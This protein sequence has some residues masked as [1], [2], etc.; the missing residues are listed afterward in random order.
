MPTQFSRRLQGRLPQD[1]PAIKPAAV[2]PVRVPL[3]EQHARPLVDRVEVVDGPRV[4]G[5]LVEPVRIER[6]LLQLPAVGLL[7]QLQRGP[8]QVGVPTRGDPDAA[9]EQRHRTDLLVRVEVR[10][11]AGL[12]HGDRPVADEV[13]EHPDRR[14]GTAAGRPRGQHRLTAAGEEE[15]VEQEAVRLMGQ[16]VGVVAA[17]R[18]R[19]VPERGRD[20]FLGLDEIAEGRRTGA[21]QV[22]DPRGQPTGRGEPRGRVAGRKQEPEHLRQRFPEPGV[23][24]AVGEVQISK[25]RGTFK[26]PRQLGEQGFGARRRHVIWPFS[27]GWAG[28]RIVRGNAARPLQHKT[29][30]RREPEKDTRPMP[31][32]RRYD[33]TRP[34]RL[35]ALVSAGGTTLQNLIDRIADGRLNSEIVSVV[36]SNPDAYGNER[37]RRA[38]IPVAIVPRRTPDFAAAV[39][40]AVRAAKP[41]LVVLAG[42]LHLLTIPPDFRF[43]VLNIHPSLLPAFGGKGM[44]GHHVH[45]AVLAYGAKVS[46]CTVH[47]A[48]D[49]YDTGPV[50]MQRAVPVLDDDTPDALTARVFAAECE[51]YPEAIR[52]IAA[53]NWRIDGRRVVATGK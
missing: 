14:L 3:A 44:Y 22:A 53:G 51:A 41:D 6:R 26:P 12:Q 35:V 29:S 11:R 18:G 47:F 24:A 21:F 27:V 49:S 8:H 25:R 46:G 45:E 50:V 43:R 39:F 10:L 30:G 48:D 7:E 4:Q 52:L 5:Q 28:R 40:D 32:P 38:G 31:D 36:S 42:W 13:V 34:P 1:E 9:E 33:L 15:S 16:Q 23:R 20:D 19:H 37:A 17:V 2:D